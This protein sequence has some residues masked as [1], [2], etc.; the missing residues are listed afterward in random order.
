MYVCVYVWNSLFVCPLLSSSR[1]DII[2]V[3][4]LLMI[5]HI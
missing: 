3:A 1:G 2:F 4:I 5:H